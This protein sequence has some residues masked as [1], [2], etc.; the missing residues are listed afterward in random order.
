MS[1]CPQKGALSTGIQ[2]DNISGTVYINEGRG[3]IDL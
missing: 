2:L 1:L 3:Y